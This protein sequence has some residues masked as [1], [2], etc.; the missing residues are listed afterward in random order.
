MARILVTEQLAERGLAAMRDAGHDV[1]ERMGLSPDELLE[2]VKG[3]HALVIRS[4]TKVTEA[5]LEAGR[6]LV[7][8]GRAGTG[9][10]N[11]DLAAA[12][13]RGVMVVNAPRANSV[14]MA[15]HTMALLLAQARNIPQAHGALKAGKWE[16]SKWEGV[17]L[18]GHTLGVLGL[19]GT[20]SLVAQR[21]HAFGMRLI[22]W[23]PWISAERARQMGV[24]LMEIDQLVAEADFI[25]IHLLKTPESTGLIGKDLLAKAKPNLRIVN[26]A[27]GGIVDEQALADAVRS[28]QIAGAALDVFSAEPTTESPLFDLPTVVVTP[29]LGASTREAQDKAGEAIAEQVVLALAGDFVPFAVNVSAAEASETVRPF[30]PLA[31]RLGRM[32]SALNGGLGSK[33]DIEYQGGLADFDTSMLTLSILKGLFGAVTEE[34]VTY[35]N[36]PQLAKERGVEYRESKASATQDFVNLIVLRGEEHAIAGTLFGSSGQHRV[37]M[38]DDHWGDVPPAKHMLVVRNDNRVGVIATVSAALAEAGINIADMDVGKSPSGETALMVLSLDHELPDEVVAGLR[39]A[40]GILD[41]RTVSG[42]PPHRPRPTLPACRTPK[43]A[44]STTPTPTSWRR[45]TGSST[46]PIRRSGNGSSRS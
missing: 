17:E 7:V 24:E 1:D 18:H 20:G 15:E 31:E 43:T 45:R 4:A 14:S 37:V 36:A 8:V 42:C 27:R 21:G 28:G 3:A 29:H 25:T 19:G 2:T 5:V 39:T 35:V 22:A 23:D 12:T 11:V 26:A 41:V 30:V 16:R 9:I 13:R 38:V 10:D 33:L 6:D 40:E 46:S 34:P 44:S 32:F